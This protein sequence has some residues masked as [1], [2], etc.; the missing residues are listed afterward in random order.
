MIRIKSK[1]R[2]LTQL[3]DQAS[4]SYTLATSH[5][6]Q[7]EELHHSSAE[8]LKHLTL[9]IQ[10]LH[11]ALITLSKLKFPYPRLLKKLP[12]GTR[13]DAFS[14]RTLLSQIPDEEVKEE[15]EAKSAPVCPETQSEPV[16]ENP[17]FL[18]CQVHVA[19]ARIAFRNGEFDCTLVLLWEGIGAFPTSVEGRGLLAK[20]LR[21]LAE[22]REEIGEVEGE[23]RKAVEA[24]IDL[25]EIVQGVDALR[26]EVEKRGQAGFN[27]EIDE[28]TEEL[29]EDV[30]DESNPQEELEEL[31]DMINTPT[32]QRELEYGRQASDNLILYLCQEG[33]S[34]EATPYL[35]HRN[36]LQRLS[37][38]VLRYPIHRSPVT[39]QNQG[40]YRPDI[41]FIKA[42]DRALP[43][44]ALHHMRKTFSPRSPFW[45][46]H[47]YGIGIPYFSYIHPLHTPPKTALDQII[48][49]LH[50]N[51]ISLFPAAAEAKYAEWWAHCRPHA[52]GHQFHFDSDDE[53]R[54]RVEGGKPHHPI[55]SSVLY[56][57]EVEGLGGPT[58]VTNQR[59]GDGLA[60]RGWMVAPRLNRFAVFDGKV[61]HGVVPGRGFWPNNDDRRVTFMVAFWDDIN[62]KA[63]RNETPGSSRPFPYS[64]SRF[65]WPRLHDELLDMED[66][67][68]DGEEV[69]KPVPCLAVPL[70]S[71]WE[72]VGEVEGDMDVDEEMDDGDQDEEDEKVEEFKYS[73]AEG[74]VPA[75]ETCFQGF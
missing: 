74:E 68:L 40:P 35:S 75:Y 63:S 73:I 43:P 10:H 34:D 22:R 53:G 25:V 28:D 17:F 27:T 58:V 3:I 13:T 19:L 66:D 69:D 42:L 15:G 29:G 71:V 21:V 44:A 56:L 24:Y 46:E 11:A 49:Q 65:S 50:A 20:T 16:P 7:S 26:E 45:S 72:R 5:L 30:E 1:A 64:K 31:E 4:D 41:P 37:D 62:V 9:T 60:T 14:I 54:E 2:W 12:T 51:A 8:S 61:L 59:I 32:F 67:G 18:Y 6:T 23:L 38:H 39:P 52:D 70:E 33:R 48:H 57:T 36:Y 55:V 47:R